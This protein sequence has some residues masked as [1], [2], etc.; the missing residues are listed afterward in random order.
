M[1]P[2]DNPYTPG[3]GARPPAL[4]GREQQLRSF[5]VL[6]ARLKGGRPEKSMLITALCANERET[7]TCSE[8][9]ESVVVVVDDL[10]VR[11]RVIHSTS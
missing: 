6:L 10:L 2:I 7:V 9:R 3:A 5:R 11:T 8:I 4:A 1:N